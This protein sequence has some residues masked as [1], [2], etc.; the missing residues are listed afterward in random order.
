MVGGRQR[1]FDV[2]AALEQAM[3]LFWK[4][5]YVGASL[6]DL[7]EC[8]GINK[9]SLYAAFGNKEQLFIKATEFYLETV[10]K[11]H[12]R[13]L[14]QPGVSLKQRM[15]DYLRSAV[16]SQTDSSGPRGCYISLCVSECAGET[17]PEQA[18]ASI[19][20]ARDFNEAFL[21]DFFQQEIAEGNL[22]AHTDAA[23][24]AL[25]I[26]TVLHGTAALSRAGKSMGDL[27]PIL[28]RVAEN[29]V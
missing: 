7:T 5:G 16:A 9:P 14:Q 17:I 10:A 15:K 22:P 23:V 29:L 6:T 26:I 27:Q 8:M 18:T 13:F 25:Y 11:K 3:H 1:E 4:K 28:D 2:E 21:R 19:Y 20:K 24:L 12:I